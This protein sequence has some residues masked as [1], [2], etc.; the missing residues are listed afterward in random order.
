M[1]KKILFLL[2]LVLVVVL[3]VSLNGKITGN[4]VSGFCS[5]SDGGKVYDKQGT[6]TDKFGSL[7]DYCK[8]DRTL[9]ENSCQ[10]GRKRVT[11]TIPCRY[12]CNEGACKSLLGRV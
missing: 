4:V 12:G 2:G 5:D 9:L 8:N 6:A 10:Q 3:V 1:E 11:E 7:T